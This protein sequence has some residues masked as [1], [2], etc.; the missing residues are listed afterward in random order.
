MR[1]PQYI[2]E[3]PLKLTLPIIFLQDDIVWGLSG[4]F[5][6]AEQLKGTQK[7]EIYCR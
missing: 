5:V 7:K 2:K 1:N 4:G 6:H 3:Y